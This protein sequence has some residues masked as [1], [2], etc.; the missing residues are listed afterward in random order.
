MTDS[1]NDSQDGNGGCL[2][3]PEYSVTFTVR[4]G[5]PESVVASVEKPIRIGVPFDLPVMFE[6]KYQNPILDT[7]NPDEYEVRLLSAAG[8]F[9][10]N[11]VRVKEQRR[12]EET[13]GLVARFTLTD[14]RDKFKWTRAEKEMVKMVKGDLEVKSKKTSFPLLKLNFPVKVGRP[15]RILL[16][17]DEEEGDIVVENGSL[18]SLGL[19]VLDACHNLVTC[20]IEPKLQGGIMV[21]LFHDARKLSTHTLDFNTGPDGNYLFN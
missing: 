4:P 8:T 14:T 10:L 6:D 1:E 15:D 21:D 2:N 11:E 9:Q 12:G 16:F 19:K 5:D 20:D 17:P 3:L 7:L 18:P 13:P